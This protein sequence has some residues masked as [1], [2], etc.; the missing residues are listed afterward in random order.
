MNYA[1][2]LPWKNYSRLWSIIGSFWIWYLKPGYTGIQKTILVLAL[3][4]SRNALRILLADDDVD[5]RDLFAEAV[6][7]HS[8]IKFDTV[9]DGVELMELLNSSDKSP[10]LI[11]LDL[12]MPGKSGKKCLEEIRKNKDLKDIPVIIYSTSSNPK[13]IEE[14]YLMGANLYIRKPNSFSELAQVIKKVSSLN[15]NEY[16]PK[17]HKKKFVFTSHGR[18]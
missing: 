17:T 7:E 8:N 3:M 15:W 4:S 5:D 1:P 16:R 11:F 10:D 2:I 14:T 6:A 13:D 18:G 12:N 9:R